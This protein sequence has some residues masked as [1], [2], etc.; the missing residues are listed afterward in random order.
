MTPR[1]RKWRFCHPFDGTNFYKPQGIPLS[2]LEIEEI[3]HDE[4]E[5]MRLCDV[6]G[7]EQSESAKKMGVSQQ[8]ISRLLSSGRKKMIGAISSGKALKIIGGEHIFP[9]RRFACGR[10]FRNGSPSTSSGQ[11]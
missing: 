9:L 7:L 11:G 4:Y 2:S 6:E 8:T 10:R 1:P 5:A 3:G